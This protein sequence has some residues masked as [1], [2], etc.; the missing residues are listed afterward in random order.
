MNNAISRTGVGFASAWIGF[1]WADHSF[2]PTLT[3]STEYVPSI[4]MSYSDSN[5]RSFV[6]RTLEVSVAEIISL[7]LS[8]EEYEAL[9]GWLQIKADGS[10]STNKAR[11]ILV[12]N[13]KLVDSDLMNDMMEYASKSSSSE[14]AEP[15]QPSVPRIVRSNTRFFFKMY[16]L[17][18]GIRNGRLLVQNRSSAG[19]I[20]ALA[21]SLVL[22]YDSG[23]KAA[24]SVA[25]ISLSYKLTYRLLTHLNSCIA[26]VLEL[27]PE[28]LRVQISSFLQKHP[29]PTSKT[30]IALAAGIVGGSFFRYFPAHAA[31][32]II[33][34]YFGVRALEVTY[35]YLDKQGY[36]SAK[37]E[38]LG[39]WALY[40]FAFGQLFH[41]FFFNP[42]SNGTGINRILAGLSRDFF[43]LTPATEHGIPHVKAWPTQDQ[44]MAGM[45]KVAQHEYPPFRSSL[46]FP[47]TLYPKYLYDVDP[48]LS[49]AHPQISTM[50]GA[51]T[52]P[53]EPSLFKAMTGV[54]LKKYS[55]IGKY[56]LAIYMLKALATIRRKKGDNK[57]SRIEIV[58]KAITDSIRTTT[59]ITMSIVTAYSGIELSERLLSSKLVPVYRFKLIGFVAGLWA[60]VDRWNGHTRFLYAVR[61]AILSFWR[62]LVKEKRVR[63]IRN[64][65]AYLFM[66]SFAVIMTIFETS[67]Q[68]ISGKLMR[69]ILYWIKNGDFK[70]PVPQDT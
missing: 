15:F 26:Y 12:P 51:L 52:H 48:V 5:S 69:K 57:I 65:D 30:L 31:R 39:S 16:F 2:Q 67:P 66:A 29:I 68:A 14:N 63:P 41:S 35:S 54:A 34:V 59:F 40:P 1:C 24:F 53:F 27:L 37:P 18:L 58:L 6:G 46:A 62:V 3:L 50:T 7:V 28:N 21:R 32:D 49:R 22:L 9:L 11:Q 47:G 61:L 55:T 4:S 44:F 25:A 42:D 10:Q 45:A 17:I 20:K 60:F 8:K 13:P 19:G 33:A 56:V 70:D 43:P 23:G 38:W 36:L 64:G